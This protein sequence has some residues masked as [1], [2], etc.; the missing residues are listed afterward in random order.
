MKGEL[1][2]ELYDYSQS[3]GLKENI[4]FT[5]YL[6]NPFN[7]M[8]KA[9]V[10]LLTSTY[11]GFSNVILESRMN[12]PVVATN[13]AGGNKEIIIDNKKWVSCKYR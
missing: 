10:L 11:E 13:S 3:L 7:I 8:K 9:D 5:G 1:K 12:V 2:K 6:K 4:I